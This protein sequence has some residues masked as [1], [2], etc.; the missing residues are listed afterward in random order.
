MIAFIARRLIVSF[1]VLLAATMVIFG[2]TAL[3]GDPLEDLR[4]SR[5][6]TGRG[7]WPTASSG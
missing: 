6:R 1:F 3:A 4:S 5:A 7:G 2:L